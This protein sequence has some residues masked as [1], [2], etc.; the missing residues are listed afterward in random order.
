MGEEPVMSDDIQVED[1]LERV[2]VELRSPSVV[3]SVRLDER[4]AKQLHELARRRHVRMSDLLREA[5]TE[6]AAATAQDA[7]RRY[8]VVY[9]RH[10]LAVG[11]GSTISLATPRAQSTQD[12]G[13][14]ESGW[15]GG[16]QTQASA[17][18]AG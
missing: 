6:Y 17:A 11:V 12:T 7:S 5:A 13:N 10:R 3:L 1:R 4:T 14:V 9:A 8:E 18:T 2:D 15:G 16:P